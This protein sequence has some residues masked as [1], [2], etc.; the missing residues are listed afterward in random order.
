MTRELLPYSIKITAWEL[1]QHEPSKEAVLPSEIFSGFPLIT[2]ES[3]EQSSEKLNKC[4]TTGTSS[5]S[6]SH[7]CKSTCNKHQK[8]SKTSKFLHTE[9]N[10]LGRVI[11]CFPSYLYHPEKK[12]NYKSTTKTNTC[13]AKQKQNV[14]K[15]YNTTI[16]ILPKNN[17]NWPSSSNYHYVPLIN[18]YH[19][20]D[21]KITLCLSS[22]NRNQIGHGPT[23]MNSNCPSPNQP[24]HEC[25]TTILPLFGAFSLPVH[26]HRH[27]YTAF[28]PLDLHPLLAPLPSLV[29][30]PHLLSL[31]PL[32]QC[33]NEAG[34]TATIL[35]L[36]NNQTL[37]I[38]NSFQPPWPTAC[39]TKTRHWIPQLPRSVEHP[40]YQLKWPYAPHKYPASHQQ[41]PI[42]L[43]GRLD[44]K[45]PKNVLIIYQHTHTDL[46]F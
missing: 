35:D 38:S 22:P 41:I 6:P 15:N 37:H 44:Y 5:S 40:R 30:T 46:N 24:T 1:C 28:D 16:F 26:R 7:I 34:Q 2:K 20:N 45:I 31:L 43:S 42:T 32:E 12:I 9:D 33:Q 19:L 29:S 27:T 39:T 36:W 4:A 3:Y 8:S 25:V 11:S 17:S 10:T 23:L 21:I 13:I 14:Y 18:P